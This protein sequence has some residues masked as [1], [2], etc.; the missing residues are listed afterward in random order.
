MSGIRVLCDTNP[1]IYLLDGNNELADFLNN[2]QIHISVITELE[3]FGKPNL[4]ETD[5]QIIETMLESC[6][7]TEINHEI[8]QIYKYIKQNYTLKLPDAVIAAT[9][10][11][12]DIP[13]LTSDYDFQKIPN[14]KL[15]YWQL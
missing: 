2:K 11:S 3:L 14:L 15:I 4:S 6:F 7:I 10:I 13:L 1:L 12:L 9:A 5:R 8:K